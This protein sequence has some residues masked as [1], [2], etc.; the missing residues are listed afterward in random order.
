MRMID[1][2]KHF[3]RMTNACCQNEQLLFNFEI[4]IFLHFAF[5]IFISADSDA[6]N[7][8]EMFF[9]V[10]KTKAN[11]YTLSKRHHSLTVL[12]LVL[13]TFSLDYFVYS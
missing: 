6:P 11:K 4:S 2:I 12:S 7:C 10:S 13:H 8:S 9:E 1:H 3:L 5:T